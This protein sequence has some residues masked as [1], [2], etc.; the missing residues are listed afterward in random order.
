MLSRHAENLFWAGRYSVRAEDTARILDVSYQWSLQARA[1]TSATL[2]GGLLDV[3]H[4][5]DAFAE[6]GERADATTV[7]AFLV[8]GETN[9]GSIVYAVGSV[10]E[11]FRAVREQLP[12]ELWRSANAFYLEL[13]NRDLAKDLR[14]R[15][16]ELYA[17]VRTRIQTLSGIVHDAMLRDEGHRFFLVGAWL[18]RALMSCRLMSVHERSVV[19]GFGDIGLIL[20][21][22]SGLQAFRRV[23]HFS[24]DV[25]DLAT[26]LLQSADFPRSVRFCIEHAAEQLATLAQ[27][28]GSAG[29]LRSQRVLGQLGSGL[30]WGDSAEICRD[31]PANLDQIEDQIR[32]ATAAIAAE[33]FLLAGGEPL[34]A[35][36]V[37]PGG[38]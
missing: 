28:P 34:H 10:R 24:S 15:P 27:R 2:W 18:E 4:L 23:H 29:P 21:A 20:R 37:F 17:L 12:L 32:D 16:F 8:W 35:Q 5:E 1:G 22:A 26:F 11:N 13:A 6:T 14:L 19:G 3:L 9:P 33:F 38:R 36:Q 30:A 7:P 25:D 31:L